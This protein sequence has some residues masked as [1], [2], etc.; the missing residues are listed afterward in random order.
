MIL[1]CRR[2]RYKFSN[3]AKCDCV[4]LL[5]YSGQFAGE[6]DTSFLINTLPNEGIRKIILLGS[7]FDSV[8]F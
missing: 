6:E 7:K 5:S 8:L 1:L 4:F 3:L 2:R